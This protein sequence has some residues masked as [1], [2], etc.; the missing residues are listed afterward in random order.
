MR[1][2][3]VFFDFDY[4]LGDGTQAIVA[5]FQYAFAQMGLPQPEREAVRRTIGMPLEDE[6][7]FLS[8]DPDPQNRARFR[9]LY[10]EKAGPMQVETV[11]MF[12]G[13]GELLSALH[14]AGV[15]AGV[16]STK[17]GDTLRAI[18]EARGVLSLFASVTGGDQVSRPKPDPEG[19]LAAIAALGLRPEQV[20]YCGDTVIDAEAAQRAGAAFCAVLNGTT[21]REDFL[22]AGF[23]CA[24]IAPDLGELERWLAL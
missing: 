16:V 24:H 6:Y 20:L 22:A 23:P 8:G 15:P 12:P 2:Q 21:G 19:L 9:A 17:R 10:T 11:R 14:R 5:G 3:A 4:T 1:Y 7:T 13:A 18:L